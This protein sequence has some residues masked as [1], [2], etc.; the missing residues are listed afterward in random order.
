MA[1]F[2]LGLGHS[3]LPR[4][5]CWLRLLEIR[6]AA[7]KYLSEFFEID[8]A[9][10]A[11]VIEAEYAIH[12]CI[13]RHN[14]SKLLNGSLELILVYSALILDVEELECFVQESGLV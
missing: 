4:G 7:D 6:T 1:R 13:V 12:V 2:Y 11:A 10:A 14:N 8:D 5:L 9:I 3:I